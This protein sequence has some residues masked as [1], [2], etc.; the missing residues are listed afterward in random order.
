MFFVWRLRVLQ[1]VD[2]Y[3]LN[4]TVVFDYR[5]LTVQFGY[6]N[7]PTHSLFQLQFDYG[8]G[9]VINPKSF[10]YLPEVAVLFGYPETRFGYGSVT[11]NWTESWLKM[12]VG[13]VT[14]YQTIF[15]VTEYPY[16]IPTICTVVWFLPHFR[17]KFVVLAALPTA[18]ELKCMNI[19]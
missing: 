4:Q 11:C 17:Q 6:D 3:Q 2:V 19:G 8:C 18:T 10:N 5:F 7:Y 12:G 14:R 15:R 1:R 9:S 13:S 16:N